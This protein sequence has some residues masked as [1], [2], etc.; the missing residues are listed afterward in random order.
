[1][2]EIN[3]GRVVVTGGT[4][5]LGQYLLRDLLDSNAELVVLTN[6]TKT[7]GLV[8]GDN[9][10]YEH[11]DYSYEGVR[12][13]LQP[14]DSFVH[15]GGS[16]PYSV[17]ASDMERASLENIL[18]SKSVFDACLHS[19]ITN[20]VFCSSIA[21]YGNQG[22]EPY[23]EEQNCRPNS[24]Y[25]VAKLSTEKVAD[26]M[27]SEYGM[28]IKSLR[29]A[30]VY[31]ARERIRSPFL[32][33]CVE[34]SRRDEAITV[35]DT[36]KTSQDYVYVKD[37]V[38]GMEKALIHSGESGAF[39]IGGGRP[40]SVEELA[41]AHQLAFGSQA[42]LLYV[43]NGQEKMFHRSLNLQ[44]SQDVLGYQPQFSMLSGC[45]DMAREY[46]LGRVPE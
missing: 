16:V 32:R 15:L 39:N 3:L 37:V 10:R 43:Q 7:E 6:R 22:T 8:S 11:C 9:I 20:V 13:C 38:Q 36:G 28:K 27:N 18:Y 25:G 14:G 35:F 17:Q 34:K 26:Y 24:I 19:G 41:K 31:G 40:V 21:V 2:R 42:G 33:I 46:A 44:K 5:F 29:I 30:Q 1:M 45:A 12:S 23:H 4:G